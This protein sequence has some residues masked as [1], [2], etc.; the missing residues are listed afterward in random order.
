MYLPGV[1]CHIIQRG[2]N[3]E[4][5][6]FSEQDYR[7]YL[8][9]LEDACKRYCVSV[10]AYVLMTNHTHVLLTPETKG[11]ISRVMQSVGRRYVQYIN[12][13]YQR[14]GT[15]WESR[16]KASLIDAEYYLFAC[17]RYIELNPVAAG[18]VRHPGEYPWSSYH[19]N[20]CGK[21]GTLL[22]P[23]LLYTGLGRTWEEQQKSYRNMFSVLLDK[24]KIHSIDTAARFSMPLGDNRFKEQ[25]EKALGRRIG[26]AKRGRP[27]S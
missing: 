17:Y 19:F 2:N 10:H 8:D 7:F 14:S 16:H 27:F 26:H 6:F 11:G 22:T 13:T 3:R 9:C 20:A 25:I 12:K 23:H 5:C 21:A 18:L 4:A 15:L 1:P 24:E